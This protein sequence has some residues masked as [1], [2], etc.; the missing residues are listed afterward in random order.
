MQR[1]LRLFVDEWCAPTLNQGRI[2]RWET[3]LMDS[4]FN[5][6]LKWL[7]IPLKHQPP[8]H[9]RLLGV[10]QFESDADIIERAADRQM[11]YLRSLQAGE[12][13]KAAQQLLNEISAAKV[14]LLDPKRKAEYDAKLQPAAAKETQN[15]AAT[16]AANGSGIHSA[17]GVVG[18][19]ALASPAVPKP[20]PRRAAT[21][22]NSGIR[23]AQPLKPPPRPAAS[24]IVIA[25]VPTSPPGAAEPTPAPKNMLPLVLAAVGAGGFLLLC[26][27]IAIIAMLPGDEPVD[28]A[29]N[30]PPNNVAANN[31]SAT[32]NDTAISH[33]DSGAN[34]NSG[35]N[36]TDT[37]TNTES[38]TTTE[39]PTDE[40]ANP[41]VEPPTTSDVDQTEPATPA[42]GAIVEIDAPFLLNSLDNDELVLSDREFVFANVA[43]Q[44]RGLDYTRWQFGPIAPFKVKVERSGDVYLILPPDQY[45]RDLPSVSVADWEDTALS[46]DVV[47]DGRTLACRV[48]RYAGK[49]KK[50]LSI[51]SSSA[52]WPIL[53][54]G[55]IHK[56]A[57]IL[58]EIVD[59]T[60]PDTPVKPVVKPPRPDKP[61]IK[62]PRGTEEE[63]EDEPE[64]QPTKVAA[65]L[66]V[67]SNDSQ[68]PIREKLAQ[69]Y[70][71]D[72]LKTPDE[73]LRVAKN[74]LDVAKEPSDKPEERYVMMA[75]GA[76]LAA[77]GGDLVSA[78]AAIDLISAD[79]DGDSSAMK[80]HLA[81]MFAK[82]S[83]NANAKAQQLAHVLPVID[84][85]LAN[86]HFD[87]IDD[88]VKEL[89]A[90]RIRPMPPELA[91][92]RK[93]ALD[94]KDTYRK[95]VSA[96]KTLA[97]N[98]DDPVANEV[99]GEY[100]CYYKLDWEQG[101]PHLAKSGDDALKDAAGGDT[102][103]PETAKAQLAV[104][105]KWYNIAKDLDVKTDERQKGS[106]LARA[107]EWYE[108][109]SGDLDG[110]DEAHAKKRIDE[111]QEDLVKMGW[112]DV[113]RKATITAA[114][115]YGFQCYLNGERLFSG[116]YG[117]ESTTATLKRGDV[118]MFHATKGTGSYGSYGKGFACVIAYE[119]NY[120]PVATGLSKGWEGYV[121]A[122]QLNWYRPDGIA[123]TAPIVASSGSGH[124][125]L[126]VQTGVGARSIW[127]AAANSSDAYFVYRVR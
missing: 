32:E 41:V 70:D 62:P 64:P 88:L 105:D 104:A 67:P 27:A 109:A 12:N 7:G 49:P 34:N 9:Y 121:P 6:Y 75:T 96:R 51:A 30:D 97:T 37:S 80:L 89:L 65:R 98:P 26:L 38:P 93:I 23:T 72:A 50:E 17:A 19:F 108:K 83:V 94:M 124:Q 52:V 85:G 8:T 110:L 84:E 125:D 87:A 107:Q 117:V 31:T 20:A 100:L 33:N 45:A 22:D 47:A 13:G 35:G 10:E 16:A 44:L 46:C 57:R 24:G 119:G 86:D 101:L 127:Y 122:N 42:Q 4:S 69:L 66:K 55:K 116:S 1:Q 60:N 126:V 102:V 56:H 99:V 82:S 106:L 79:F 113:P 95:V 3:T 40:S 43:R 91:G 90:A 71:I 115:G 36:S 59:N 103:N 48:L 5:P 54:V 29:Q 21:P 61:P 77:D 15:G 120:T 74:L 68:K 78:L 76:Q 123:S 63:P 39:T 53:A 25:A 11:T 112:V 92:R 73:K 118:L 111:V 58:G 14:C 81:R 114:S 18:E 2:T 28:V